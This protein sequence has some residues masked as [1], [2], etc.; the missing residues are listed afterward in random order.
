MANLPFLEEAIFR[1][2]HQSEEKIEQLLDCNVL[3][4]YGEIRSW[5]I[6]PFRGT[7]EAL[8]K[9][10]TKKDTLAICLQTPGGEAEAVEKMVDIVRHHYKTV[11]FIVPGA[12]FS[13]GT[14]F[15]MSGDKIFMDYSSSLGPID[16]Q[17][18]DKD[19]KHLVPALG[20]L[21]KVAELV[22]KSRNNTISPAEVAILAKQDL[23]ML[24][25]YEQAKDL[26][27]ALLK[28]WLTTYKFKDWTVHRTTNPGTPVTQADK[29]GRATQIATLLSDNKVWHSHGRMISMNTLRSVLKLEI[30]DFGANVELRDA[31]RSYSDTLTD[32]LHRQGL[33]HYLHNRNVTI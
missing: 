30:D 29:E 20:Y 1:A 13:A 2:V 5:R 23:A 8:A 32:Y 10:V 31:V 16:P 3:F 26:S 21:D 18:P 27:I 14:I 28:T 12:A 33:Q 25:F 17:V 7:I 24:R 19:G 22:Q 9:H 11:Y 4:F 15:C 6:N